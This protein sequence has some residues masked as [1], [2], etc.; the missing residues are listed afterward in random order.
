MYEY[1]TQQVIQR[2][3]RKAEELL[4]SRG[5]FLYTEDPSILEVRSRVKIHL[6]PMTAA[7]IIEDG[8]IPASAYNYAIR[9]PVNAY[10]ASTKRI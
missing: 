4:A 1:F 9:E 5:S 10:L 2:A 7:E 6:H 8:S 3:R